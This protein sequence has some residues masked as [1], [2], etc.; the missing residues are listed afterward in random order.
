ME[1]ICTSCI[2]LC[3]CSAPNCMLSWHLHINK[4]WCKFCSKKLGAL[5]VGEYSRCSRYIMKAQ[6]RQPWS[7]NQELHEKPFDGWNPN[8]T[9]KIGVGMGETKSST[10][11]T[12]T[13]FLGNLRAHAGKRR[14]LIIWLFKSSKWVRFFFSPGTLEAESSSAIISMAETGMVVV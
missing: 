10:W 13:Y 11:Y 14:C 1:V 5:L 8:Q 4:I 7:T 12:G 3:P 9:H 2:H 6:E